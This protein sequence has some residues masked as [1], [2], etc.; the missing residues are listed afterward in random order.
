VG[1][2]KGQ[3]VASKITFIPDALPRL[4]PQTRSRSWPIRRPQRRPKRLR[5]K[6]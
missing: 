3:L 5:T 4:Q 2:S 1:N 6:A